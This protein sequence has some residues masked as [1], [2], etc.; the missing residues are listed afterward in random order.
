[1]VIS[2]WENWKSKHTIR[3]MIHSMQVMNRLEFDTYLTEAKDKFDLNQSAFVL[4]LYAGT[5]T[6][7]LYFLDRILGLGIDSNPKDDKGVS[8]LHYFVEMG[9]IEATEMLLKKAVNP[10]VQD[11]RGITPLHIANSYDGLGDISDLLLS[12]GADPNLR[13]HIGKRYL[14]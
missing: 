11:P 14:M 13:D 7:D 1:M 4:M 2:F 9:R 10:N 12:Y 6:E 5:E 3:K 8:L